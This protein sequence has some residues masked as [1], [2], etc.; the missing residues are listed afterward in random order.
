MPTT[1]VYY[2]VFTVVSIS[3]LFYFCNDEL[4]TK[5]FSQL[6]LIMIGLGGFLTRLRFYLQVIPIYAFV[7]WILRTEDTIGKY[8]YQFVMQNENLKESN[9]FNFGLLGSI[10]IQLLNRQ[11]KGPITL[12]TKTIMAPWSE[13][14]QKSIPDTMSLHPPIN[15]SNITSNVFWGQ[16]LYPF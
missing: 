2:T 13:T 1:W 5:F 10:G 12:K 14:W 4:Q 6:R 11:A 7:R 15:W 9:V 8:I 3:F 16:L